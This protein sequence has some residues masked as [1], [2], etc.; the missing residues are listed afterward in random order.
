MSLLRFVRFVGL[1]VDIHVSFLKNLKRDMYIYKEPNKSH[2]SH[3]TTTAMKKLRESMGIDQ[4]KEPCVSA[5][6]PYI[7][8]KGPCTSAKEP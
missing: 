4:W 6:E 3:Y 5:K 2:K 8:A 1:F 7:S